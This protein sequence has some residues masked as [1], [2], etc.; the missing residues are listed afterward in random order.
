M[1][2]EALEQLR[3]RVIDDPRRCGELLQSADLEAFVE[4][5][6]ATAA[7]LGIELTSD[8][9]TAGLSEAH[10]ARLARWV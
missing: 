6:L 8:E 2:S 9:V 4:N 10:L 7:D 5:T 1:A 3:N